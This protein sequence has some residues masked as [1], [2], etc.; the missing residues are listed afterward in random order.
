MP[1]ALR[2]VFGQD[3][4]SH[5]T[6]RYRVGADRVLSVPEEVAFYLLHNAGFH[7]I[8]TAG[9]R[10]ARPIRRNSLGLQMLVM[11]HHPNAGA[12]SYGGCE[13]RVDENGNILVPA[14]AV[15]DLVCHGFAPI[16]PG[17]LS[18][19]H[20]QGVRRRAVE[21]ADREPQGPAQ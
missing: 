9:S 20:H 16:E 4:V 2:A 10:H 1:I 19:E 14:D 21:A 7:V 3:E 5:G 12:C 6:E 18:Q 11:M 15:S 17:N 8:R 13:Y